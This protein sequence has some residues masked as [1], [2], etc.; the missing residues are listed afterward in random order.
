MAAAI[1]SA[2]QRLVAIIPMLEF[3]RRKKRGERLPM[4]LK[5]ADG[6]TVSVSTFDELARSISASIGVSPRTVWNWYCKYKHR[7]YSGLAHVRAD[8]GVSRA[9]AHNFK[10]KLLLQK[11][12]HA[13]ASAAC[14]HRTL[15][16][17]FG[18]EAPCYATVRAHCKA[19]ER[20]KRGSARRRN[21][22]RP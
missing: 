20:G 14:I 15:K 12:C 7:Q 6:S 1:A 2:E 22:A 13:G 10:A 4:Q 8:R 18:A 19:I 9:F 5:L 3:T 11:A 21:G 17:K 16:I